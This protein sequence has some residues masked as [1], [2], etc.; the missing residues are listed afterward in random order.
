MLSDMTNRGADCIGGLALLMHC[1]GG[2]T[3][4]RLSNV[5]YVPGVHLIC[6]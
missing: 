5:A 1:P 2:E 3:R 6:S 4:V